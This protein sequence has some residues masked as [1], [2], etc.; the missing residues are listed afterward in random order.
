MITTPKAENVRSFPAPDHDHAHCAA[1]ALSRA[2]AICRA[3]NARLTALRQQVLAAVWES[4]RP[5]GA[6]DILA[7]MNA[8]GGRAAPMA[9][10]R[11]LDFLQE[12][13]LVHRIASLNAFV[14]C[15]QPGAL[16]T[17]QFLIC[18][19]CHTAA[20]FDSAPLKDALARTI[21]ASGFAVDSQ[22][23]E[24]TGLCPNCRALPGRKSQ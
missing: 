24:I 23:V 16:H 18:R 13:G 9:V 14:G 10:Y 6:Y 15:A 19:D 2:E 21:D 4:H 8:G 11:A 22:I 12:Q 3:K 7:R 1:S 5:I 20:E 17:A